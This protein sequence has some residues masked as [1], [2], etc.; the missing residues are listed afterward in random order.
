[1]VCSSTRRLFLEKVDLFGIQSF[2]RYN[3][4][5]DEHNTSSDY[6]ALKS[7]WIAIGNDMSQVMELFASCHKECHELVSGS[8]HT[9]NAQERDGADDL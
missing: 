4:S 7:D 1:M 6:D 3:N 2:N 5:A 8:K 9:I